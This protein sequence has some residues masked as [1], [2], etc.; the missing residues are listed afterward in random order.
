MY[1]LL[2]LQKIFIVAGAKLRLTLFCQKHKNKLY[3]C[4]PC[5]II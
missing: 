3:M 4:R 1:Y 5:V 2:D